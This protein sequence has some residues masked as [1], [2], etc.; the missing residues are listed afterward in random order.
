MKRPTIRED[1]AEII[2]WL[3]TGMIMSRCVEIA[4]A[5]LKSRK[6]KVTRRR[7]VGRKG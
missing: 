6:F 4:D 3:S 7:A 5:I 2:W 1:L